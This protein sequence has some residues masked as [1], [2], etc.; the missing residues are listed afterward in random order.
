MNI[1]GFVSAPAASTQ[2]FQSYDTASGLIS[3]TTSHFVEAGGHRYHYLE[4]NPANFSLGK[5]VLFHGFPDFSYG[6]LYQ[7]PYQ[8]SLG[9]R[10]IAPDLLGFADT[11]AP[12]DVTQYALKMIAPGEK[13]I[14][15]GYDWGAGLA[16]N[17]AMWYPD[18]PKAFITIGIPYTVPW[19][20]PTLEW[21][22]M[23]DLARDG[24]YPTL[25]HQM[26]WRDAAMDRNFMTKD[27]IRTFFNVMFGAVTPEGQPAISLSE[28]I[29]YDAIPRLGNQIFLSP[30]DFDLYVDKY[31]PE[32]VATGLNWYRTRRMNYEDELPLAVKGPFKFKTPH[33]FLPSLQDHFILPEMSE[34]MG[35]YLEKET[36]QPVDAGHFSMWE[37]PEEVN[38]ILGKWIAGF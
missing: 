7:V 11:D 3:G 6:W 38:E 13:F 35:Q 29:P 17:L 24:T 10:V 22:D 12:C 5:V 2:S 20:G 36:V 18:Y 33:L 34:D 25:G 1:S 4:S 32:G 26:Q 8:K 23:M 27:Q 15:G 14:L 28:G 21:A 16:Y 19:L 9:Y 30:S 37:E 31:T